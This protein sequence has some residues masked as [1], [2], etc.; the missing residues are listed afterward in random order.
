M[1]HP[2]MRAALAAIPAL[3]LAGAALLIAGC[4]NPLFDAGRGETVLPLNRAWVDGRQVE[5]VTTD[6]SD[7][8]MASMLGVNFVPRLALATKAATGTSLLE[9]VYKFSRDEQI[10]V[11]Q[12]GPD[13][14]GAANADRDYSPLWRLVLVTWTVPAAVR[15]LR[16]EAEILAAEERRELTLEVTGVVVNCPVTRGPDGRAL[17]GVR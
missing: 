15:E 13:P 14:A 2:A 3:V 4:A 5:Y 16:S 8:A 11:F 1:R 10:S 17:R 6:V 12:S 7:A 9:R